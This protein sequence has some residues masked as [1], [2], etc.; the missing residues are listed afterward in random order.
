M[1]SLSVYVCMYVCVCV[2]IYSTTAAAAK[3]SVNLWQQIT[4][5]REVVMG[6]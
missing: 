3:N 2:P 1:L 6:G 4:N 5:R